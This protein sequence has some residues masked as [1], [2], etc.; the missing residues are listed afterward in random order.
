MIGLVDTATAVFVYP[1][2]AQTAVVSRDAQQRALTLDPL[3]PITITVSFKPGDTF[4]APVTPS[5]TRIDIDLPAVS[6][7]TPADL[8]IAK[9]LSF[10]RLG[11][12]WDGN[13]AAAPVSSS[14]SGARTFLRA[15]SPE[16]QIPQPTL[17]A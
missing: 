10:D 8:I 17:H 15:L 4:A 16:S 9:L 1:E 7:R 13:H 12:D 5:P 6:S 14:I 2:M 3:A 11:E